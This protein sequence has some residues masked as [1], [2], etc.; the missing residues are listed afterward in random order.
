MYDFFEIEDDQL[1]IKK[2]HKGHLITLYLKV[3]GLNMNLL[4]TNTVKKI[5]SLT[6][7]LTFTQKKGCN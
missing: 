5:S 6:K 3:E 4:N 2:W 1:L 7:Q